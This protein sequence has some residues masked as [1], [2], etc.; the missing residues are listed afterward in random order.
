MERR[1]FDEAGLTPIIGQY[2]VPRGE[3]P[4]AQFEG[5]SEVLY[6]AELSAPAAR[7]LS[8]SFEDFRAVSACAWGRRNTQYTPT[9]CIANRPCKLML[10]SAAKAGKTTAAGCIMLV[11]DPLDRALS[12]FFYTARAHC[13]GNEKFTLN[14]HISAMVKDQRA[15]QRA[16]PSASTRNHNW[17]QPGDIARLLL[18]GDVWQAAFGEHSSPLKLVTVENFNSDLQAVDNDR[19]T[20]AEANTF[21]FAL[22]GYLA[23]FPVPRTYPIGTKARR[24]SPG[25]YGKLLAANAGLWLQ[26]CCLFADDFKLYESA[27]CVQP[28]FTQGHPAHRLCAP[29]DELRRE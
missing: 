21:A 29:L 18:Q 6:S 24:L 8:S 15:L 9:H 16:H 13:C 14:D 27:V 17:K 19:K 3:P 11:R 20:S 28:W 1:R 2:V 10:C 5:G 7:A 26:V 4:A 22:C 23:A 25:T 12:S